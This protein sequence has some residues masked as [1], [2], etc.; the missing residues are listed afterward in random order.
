MRAVGL[1]RRAAVDDGHGL[2]AFDLVDDA[3]V[4]DEETAFG[5]VAL[6]RRRR[7]GRGG[8]LLDRRCLRRCEFRQAVG[9]LP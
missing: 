2:P 9:W 5:D 7:E 4:A 8:L 1:Q 3:V 6:G